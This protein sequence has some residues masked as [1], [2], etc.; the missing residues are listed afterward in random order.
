MV[1]NVVVANQANSHTAMAKKKSGSNQE[2]KV[3]RLARLQVGSVKPSRPIE[4]KDSRRKPK[5]KPAP[6]DEE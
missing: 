2:K 6:A 1:Q 5:H 3:R 4:P